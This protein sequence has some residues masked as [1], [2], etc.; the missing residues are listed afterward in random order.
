M[1]IISKKKLQKLQK[2][3]KENK[4]LKEKLIV[5]IELN[6]IYKKDNKELQKTLRKSEENRAN[7]LEDFFEAINFASE[8]RDKLVKDINIEDLYET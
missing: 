4:N 6:D 2:L 8:V 3:E 7:L 1:K 5:V